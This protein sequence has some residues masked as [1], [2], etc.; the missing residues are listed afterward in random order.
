MFLNE[1]GRGVFDCNIPAYPGRIYRGFG[2]GRH[3]APGKFYRKPRVC[4]VTSS[5]RTENVKATPPSV[6]VRFTNWPD[7]K[8]R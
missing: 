2:V 6:W 4:G 5:R 3:F 1:R 7:L 8:A